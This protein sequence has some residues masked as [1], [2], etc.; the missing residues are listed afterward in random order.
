MINFVNNFGTFEYPEDFIEEGLKIYLMEKIIIDKITVK[1]RFAKIDVF[2]FKRIKEVEILTKKIADLKISI[3]ANEEIEISLSY[4]N[5]YPIIRYHSHLRH[6]NK[7]GEELGQHKHYFKTDKTPNA[8]GIEN[9]E[10]KDFYDENN[11][12]VTLRDFFKECN[13]IYK[14][15][16]LFEDGRLFN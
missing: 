7:G 11:I 2:G 4:E 14:P 13:I 12:K 1:K 16:F 15:Q 5:V 9:I 10:R 6:H 3:D 8:F